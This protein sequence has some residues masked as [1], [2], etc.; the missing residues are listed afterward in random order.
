MGKKI[1][2]G[3][4]FGGK[5]VEHEVSVQSARNVY[6]AIDKNKYH[7]TMIGITKD[8]KWILNPD[9]T[10]GVVAADKGKG[11]QV[12]PLAII[13]GADGKQLIELGGENEFDK[14]DVI[15]PILH[16]PYG[17]DG[18]VQG[19]LRLV[20]IPFVGPDVL[21][22]AV[23]MDKEVMKRL[24]RDSQIPIADYL[25]I[26]KYG[27]DRSNP[28]YDEIEAFLGVPFFVK[29]ANTGSSVGISKV[30][31]KDEF[32]KAVEEAFAFDSKVIVEKNII[33]R[34]I[35]CAVLGNEDPIAS[36]PGEVR[37][38]Y[39]FYSY[40]AKYLDE[41][42][43]ALEIPA[44]LPKSV[45]EKIQETAIKVFKAL[46]CEGMSRVDIFLTEQQEIIV[47][48]INTIPGFTKISMYPKLWEVS[49]IPYTQLIDRLIQL[50]VER[51]DRQMK[52]KTSI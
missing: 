44:N 23:G 38:S 6:D 46:C 40:E 30:N 14:L 26:F 9:V 1:H 12:N 35:E 47:N 48:E 33:G 21:G 52:L 27:D 50:A 2:V 25:T 19:L 7:V 18:T 37:S 42:G 32:Q 43:A 8:G 34:E 36:L 29:P 31:N 17:E 51:F 49:G 22:S 5:S 10:N 13:P 15:F 41:H 28:T 11:I 4:L 3:I 39:S 16:G 20:N 24:L 45:I